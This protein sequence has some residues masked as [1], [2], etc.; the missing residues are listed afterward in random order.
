MELLNP[1]INQIIY[2]V[3]A[4]FILLVVLSKV[5]FP[6]IVGMLQKRADVIKE[7]L[8]TAERTREEAAKL[9]DDYKQQIAEARAEAQ[10]IIEQGR[11]FGDSMKEEIVQKAK[12][13]SEQ[14][15]VRATAEIEREK[16]LALTALQHQVADLTIGA[17]SRVLSRDLDKKS[18]EQLIEQYL[19]E[20]GSL[21]EN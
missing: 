17:A 8:D 20:A 4:F 3:V 16:E 2:S 13:E 12:A 9:M 11:K 18:H 7:S 19:A 15:L 10:K 14:L 1:H 5:A 21:G 6:P